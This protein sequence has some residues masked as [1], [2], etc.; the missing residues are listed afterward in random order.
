MKLD[1]ERFENI[2]ESPLSEDA[3][4]FISTTNFEYRVAN[5]REINDGL[6]KYINFLLSDKQ[7][8]GPGYLDIWERGWQENLESYLISRELSDLVPKFI[9]QNQL[10]RLEG[11]WVLPQNPDFE[12]NFVTVMRDTVFRANF[13]DAPSVWEFGPGTGLSLVHLSEIYPEKQLYGCDWA[14][15]SVNIIKELKTNLGLNVR[16]IHFDLFN[17]DNSVHELIAPGAGLFTICTL[18]QLGKNFNPFLNFILDSNFKRCV[19]IETNFEMYDDSN[20]LDFLAKRYI[21]KRNWLR[22]YSPALREL[23]SR[24]V[25][26]IIDERKT[27]GSFFHDGYT[28]TIWE[29]N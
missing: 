19:N 21:E 29:R 27:I 16:G 17:P 22:G 15:P 20:V 28:I 5:E 4:K 7:M 1:V 11:K 14:T 6:I 13:E 3:K 26:S 8:S 18:E 10:V 2:F 23:E 24:G 9:R 25:I 12:N